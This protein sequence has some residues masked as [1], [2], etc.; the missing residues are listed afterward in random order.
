MLYCH[1][2]KKE[3]FIKFV[4]E[5]Y[6]IESQL[7]HGLHD[8]LNAD[9][10][11]GTIENK[12]DAVDWIT[13]SFLYRRISQNPNYYNLAGRT[14]TH[15]NDF[16][17]ELIET[18]VE[19]LQRAKCLQQ[20]DDDDMDLEPANLGRIAAYYYIRYQ[21]IEHFAKN[22]EDEA[23]LNKKMRFL[24]EVLAKSSEFE[25][26]PIRQGETALLGALLPHATY[27][28]EAGQL[29]TPE[30]K[31][32]LLLQCHFNR[33]GLSSDLR[34]DQRFILEQAVK[35]VHAMVDV[36]SSHGYLKPALLAME[37]CQQIVQAMW[38]T[39]SPLLQ[40]P[41][42]DLETVQVLKQHHVEDVVDFM[43]MDDALRDK[44]LGVTQHQMAIIADACNRYPNIEME[45]EIERGKYADGEQI[46]AVVTISRPDVES[47]EDLQVFATP[48]KAQYYPGAKEE[49]WWLVVGRPKLNKLY[50]IKKVTT[51]KNVQELQV[52]MS[53]AAKKEA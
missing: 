11:A 26:V 27:P 33:T 40:L 2:P 53:F 20:K 16:L 37:L 52:K 12:Q 45:V 15:I 8:H 46:D 49:Q 9:V 32:N 21:T 14:G 47:E 3:Y 31:A 6:P 51:F 50:S 41:L 38:V 28:L 36:I 48:V 13:W 44:L 23:T 18:T 35:L 30:S 25:S 39:Q 5:P 22:L 19:D 17:S 29:N 34:T 24:L 42:I 4:Q 1:T 10:V 43:N 7:D